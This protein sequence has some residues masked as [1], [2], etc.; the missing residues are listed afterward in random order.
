MNI[1]KNESLLEGDLVKD[2]RNNFR[3]TDIKDKIICFIPEWDDYNFLNIPTYTEW[4]NL[5]FALNQESLFQKIHFYLNSEDH[6]EFVA[7]Q[8]I[9]REDVFFN[10]LNNESLKK[11][12]KN[13]D[14]I[15]KKSSKNVKLGR[16]INNYITTV[17]NLNSLTK[18][19]A[20]V[21]PNTAPYQDS[22]SKPNTIKS[23][24]R[25]LC[26]DYEFFNEKFI[27]KFLNFIEHYLQGKPL[28]PEKL[29]TPQYKLFYELNPNLIGNFWVKASEIIN[30][31]KNGNFNDKDFSEISFLSRNNL[32]NIKKPV[33]W[34][35]VEN[36]NGF[37]YK[38]NNSANK[39]NKETKMMDIRFFYS[40]SHLLFFEL[41]KMIIGGRCKACGKL[42]PTKY[43]GLYCP[44]S[45]KK[46]SLARNR[47]KQRKHY[48]KL[49]NL[50]SS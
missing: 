11:M 30:K 27:Y 38:N 36:N 42:L 33:F 6:L 9:S 7:T 43:K 25:I 35:E 37:L 45:N 8:E 10:E 44:K 3:F 34:S 50:T 32:Q 49:K 31:V 28:N 14:L 24:V 4:R 16:L 23:K 20:D 41:T 26:V 17:D 46:C 18:H 48:T 5:M 40:F 2:F 1:K 39:K 22:I 47:E 19:S 15:H 29:K 21:F 13:I 12:V